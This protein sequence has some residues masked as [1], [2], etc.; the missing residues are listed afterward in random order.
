MV[1]SWPVGARTIP[2]LGRILR[3]EGFPIGWSSTAVKAKSSHVPGTPF[4]SLVPTPENSRP[5]PATNCSIVEVTR[6]CPGP[7]TGETRA[8]VVTA[9]P[10]TFSPVSSASPM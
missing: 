9:M 3:V 6:T 4:S 7:A 1:F 2:R 10:L 5:D 8:A